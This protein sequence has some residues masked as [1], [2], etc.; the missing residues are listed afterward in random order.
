MVMGEGAA[1]EQSR[2]RR[3]REEESGE[4]EEGVA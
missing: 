1:T 2:E 3:G 4:E